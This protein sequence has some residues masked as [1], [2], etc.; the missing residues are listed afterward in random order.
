[1]PARLALGP[2]GLP[3]LTAWAGLGLA[4]LRAGERLVVSAAAGTVGAV[5][6]QL[7]LA[8]GARVLG[9][10]AGAK[11]D[12]VLGELGLPAAVARDAP[13]FRARLAAALPE[14]LDVYFDNVGGELLDA[15]L[16]HL[17]PGARVVLCGMIAQYDAAE[18]PPGP[19]LGRVIAARARLLG[20][21]VYDHL[22]R[23]P[24]FLAEALPLWRA[25]RLRCAERIFAGLERAPEAFAE[26]LSGRSHGRLLVRVGEEGAE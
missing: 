15:A 18:R 25:G 23:L 14:G 3:G 12:Y 9:I 16:D 13:D 24:E 11:L 2:L 20:L 17:R 10:T 8:R 4:G 21:V 26:L 22:G 19:N 7:G 6:A 5:A 1:M